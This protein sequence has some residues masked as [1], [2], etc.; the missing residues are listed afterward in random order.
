M[1]LGSVGNAQE[2]ALRI[3]AV[4][5]EGRVLASTTVNMRGPWTGPSRKGARVIGTEVAGCLA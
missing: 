5:P 4:D 3:Q 1:R 2:Y